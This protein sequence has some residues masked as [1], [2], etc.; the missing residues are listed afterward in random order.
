MNVA[1]P[2]SGGAEPDTNTCVVYSVDSGEIVHVHT[3]TVFPGGSPATV[4]ALT[5]EAI[6]LARGRRHVSGELGVQQVPAHE[7][8]PGAR[9][10]PAS[11]RLIADQQAT[12]KR[13]T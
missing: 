7:V 6:G 4:E 1:T 8:A 11:G 13:D 3:I 9:I 2:S 5:Q 10:D 12:G